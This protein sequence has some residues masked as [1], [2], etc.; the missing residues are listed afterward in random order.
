M[1]VNPG[2]I[3]D[4]AGKQVGVH[5]GICHF[6]IGQRKGLKVSLGEPRYVVKIN[7]E[8]NSIVLGKKEDL[9][10]KVLFASRM[11]FMKAEELDDVSAWAK[12]RSTHQP[13]KCKIIRIQEDLY[14]V[15]FDEP[16]KA[17]APGQAIVFYDEKELILGGGWIARS[18]ISTGKGH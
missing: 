8:E 1:V 5:E 2:A 13:A 9:Y 6:T 14:Q 18:K 10:Q 3:Y 7:Q 16:Q 4:I 11:S 15:E 12:I 17:V